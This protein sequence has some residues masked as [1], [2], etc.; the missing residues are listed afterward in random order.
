MSALL[1]KQQ[2]CV[3]R[4]ALHVRAA[5][6]ATRMRPKTS[7]TCPPCLRSNKDASKEKLYMS[8]LLG[9]RQGCP[10][11]KLYMFALLVNQRGYVQR[12]ALH[13]V[14]PVNQQ[15]CVLRQA[16]HLRSA[17]EPTMMSQRQALHVCPVCEVIRMHPKTR[18]TCP[19]CGEATRIQGTIAL[20]A[21]TINIS[22]QNGYNLD[23]RPEISRPI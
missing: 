17:C 16:L 9:K 19:R 4:Q 14:L 2:G 5:W 13:A 23:H 11:D 3:Q 12:L 6:E 8:A 15:G 18:F 7:F 20:S 22:A 21:H 1:G 10:K